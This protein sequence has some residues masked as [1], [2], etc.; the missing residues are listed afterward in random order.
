MAGKPIDLLCLLVACFPTLHAEK[1]DFDDFLKKFNLSFKGDEHSKRSAI[2]T[3][4]LKRI[5]ELKLKGVKGL[6]INR[7]A[8]TSPEEFQK[9]T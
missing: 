7:F 5:E 8:A 4:N 9:V 1:P 3:E 6:G 2:F